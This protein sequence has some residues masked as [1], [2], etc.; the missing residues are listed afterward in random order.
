MHFRAKSP[1]ARV[2]FLELLHRLKPYNREASKKILSE[3]ERGSLLSVL[4]LVVFPIG[5]RRVN[6]G[7]VG[8]R[9]TVP[10][11]IVLPYYFR[12]HLNGLQK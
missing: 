10:H 4:S 9:V 3:R 11:T 12:M 8:S 7:G 6:E 2:T 5:R 1:Y